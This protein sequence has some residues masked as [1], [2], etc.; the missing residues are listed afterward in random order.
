M[1]EL[2]LPSKLRKSLEK[3][4]ADA[5]IGLNAHIIKKLEANTPPV[6]YIKPE[7]VHEQLP[8]LVDFLN[9]IPAVKVMS[10]KV[11]PDAFW[12]IKLEI[13]TTH[14]LAW[15]A[16]EHLGFVL[17]YI[18]LNERLPTIFMPVAAPP[19]LNGGGPEFNLSWVIES[20]YNYIPPEDIRAELE[21]RLPSPVDDE[22]EW[23][24]GED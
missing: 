21:G 2:N 20:K 15:H 16:V 10:S 23:L 9:R 12:W 22:S 14:R 4:A 1:I 3:E 18:S 13:D 7:P 5:Q 11:T 24:A 17:N 19:Y 6:E 8:Q